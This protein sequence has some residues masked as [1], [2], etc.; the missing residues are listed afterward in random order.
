M[1]DPLAI[2]YLNGEF[3]PLREARVSP[4][5]RAF[6]Y[7]DA[8]Y[9][10]MPVYAGRVFR[11]TQ[12]FDRLDRSL[13]EIRMAPVYP[14]ARWAEVCQEL[15][16]RN[17]G[18]DMYLY[19]QVTRGAEFGRNH[20]PL[21]DIERTVFA[22][23]APPV[24]NAPEKIER[25]IAVVTAE[26]TRWSRCDVKSTALLAN[27]L[28]KQL[29]VDAGAHETIMLRNQELREGSSTT[30]HVV[31]GGEIR[32]PPRS[33]HILPGTT[34]D[35]VSELAS[36]AGLRF[37]SCAVSEAELRSADEIFIGAATFGT[38]AVT[39]LDGHPVGNGKPG[40]VWKRIRELFE[41]YKR[42]LAG[43]PIEAS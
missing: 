16:R 32:T 42:E 33:P 15:V 8:V 40:P 17:G 34:R 38:L 22:F 28:L 9:E 6:L 41:D 4:L 5:D 14:R 3:L 12:H 36:R 13:K 29:A 20:A 21:P 11:F 25:G 19:V 24:V 30:V 26:D 43:K 10:V 31:V 23:A 27:I 37:R 18:G 2:A 1:A 39:S 7:G 35:V